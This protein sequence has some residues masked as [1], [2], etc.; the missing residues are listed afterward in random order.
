[1]NIIWAQQSIAGL[2]GPALF[3]AGPTL[4][5][6]TCRECHGVRTVVV[7]GTV[8]CQDA[9]PR[10]ENQPD[11]KE[12]SWRLE[13]LSYLEGF[14]YSGTVFVPEF[15]G[16]REW[17]DDD[18]ARYETQ[19]RWETHALTAADVRAFWVPRSVHLP[20]YTTNVE[21]GYWLREPRRM[22][23]GHPPDA[24]HTKYLDLCARE[25]DVPIY[26]TLLETLGGAVGK[27]L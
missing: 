7:S 8:H 22:V 26:S 27:T 23:L 18:R 17:T 20:G 4:R 16:W 10:C 11:F 1:M 25:H 2:R 5:S 3:L 12:T 19:V 6:R 21:F 15:E 13:A 9:C 14:G 24:S